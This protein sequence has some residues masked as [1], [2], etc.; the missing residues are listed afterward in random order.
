[1]V[2]CV[3]PGCRSKGVQDKG[4]GYYRIPTVITS[5]GEFEEELTAER[6]KEWIK[7]ISHSNMEENQVLKSKRV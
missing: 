3:N 5:K 2:L 4:I 6:R 7:V 1:M